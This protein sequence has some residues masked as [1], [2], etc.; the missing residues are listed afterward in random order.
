MKFVSSNRRQNAPMKPVKPRSERGVTLIELLIGI[1]I[2][3]LVSLAAVGSLVFNRLS[4][5]LVNDTVAMQQEASTIMRMVGRQ[6]RQAGA[7]GVQDSPGAPGV[8]KYSYIDNYAGLD[9]VN[10]VIS[11]SGQDSGTNFDGITSSFSISPSIANV[12]GDCRGQSPDLTVVPPPT[13]V[14]SR[15]NVDPNN[16]LM[17]EGLD[18]FPQPTGSNVEEFQVWYAIRTPPNGVIPAQ[19][20]YYTADQ[21]V[22]PLRW[23]QVQAVQ[24]CLRLSG[25]SQG[26]P[27]AAGGTVDCLGQPVAADGRIRRVYQRVFTMRNLQSLG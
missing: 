1:A 25:D 15:F 21:I 13:M 3:L 22:A 4:A 14:T 10:G 6:L 2:G 9:P 19:I 5:T 18:G 7:V 16:N 17:C 23:D 26:N 24:V 11:I 27:V 20:R 12:I 8:G